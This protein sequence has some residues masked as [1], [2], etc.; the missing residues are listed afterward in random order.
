MPPDALP[1]TADL[2]RIY[3]GNVD[4]RTANEVRL[5]SS[6][7]HDTEQKARQSRYLNDEIVNT[8]SLM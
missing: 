1:E 5:T 6:D 8:L 4:T 2:H 3:V 7:L